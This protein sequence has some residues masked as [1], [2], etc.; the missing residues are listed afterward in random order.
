MKLSVIIPVWN[1]PTSL[2]ICLAALALQDFPKSDYEVIVADNGSK[3]PPEALVAS[4]GARMIIEQMPGSYAARNAAIKQ[5][6]GTILAFTDADCVPAP[7]WLR[8]GVKAL[9][10]AGSGVFVGG[11]I[12]VIPGGEHIT[13]IE[14]YDQVSTFRQ[15]RNIIEG[16]YAMTANMFVTVTDFERVGAFSAVLKSGG[17]SEWSARAVA[18][19]LKPVYSDQA[20]VRHPSRG[21]QAEVFKKLKRLAGGHRDK[22]PSWAECM[23]FTLRHAVPPRRMLIDI[24]STDPKVADLSTKTRAFIFAYKCRLYYSWARLYLQITGEASKRA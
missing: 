21:S 12:D 5:V 3:D 1:D 22:G 6:R 9:E 18:A 13:P 17:D 7:N 16:Q 24:F 8:E 19:G 4:F 2:Q 20:L 15:E 14:L 11:R 10:A 23:R